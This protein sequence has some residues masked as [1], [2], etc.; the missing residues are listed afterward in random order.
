MTTLLLVCY[1]I[2]QLVTNNVKR[3]KKGVMFKIRKLTR[4]VHF[5][6]AADTCGI[7]AVTLVG[8]DRVDARIEYQ[9]TS[10]T[11]LVGS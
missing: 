2:K 7:I 4:D 6:R 3:H 9:V 10:Y 5:T 8:P 1:D 11:L